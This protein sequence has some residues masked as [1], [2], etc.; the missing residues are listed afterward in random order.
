MILMEKNIG[1]NENRNN[2]IAIIEK[3]FPHLM[4]LPGREKILKSTVSFKKLWREEK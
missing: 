4:D 2:I 1:F 3:K